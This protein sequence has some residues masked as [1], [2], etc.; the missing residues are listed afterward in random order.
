MKYTKDVPVT[1]NGKELPYEDVKLNKDK[2]K[3]RL[4]R[5]LVCPMNYLQEWLDKIQG[6]NQANSVPTKEFFIK[7]NG[8]AHARQMS[9]IRKLVSEYDNFIRTNRE[10]LFSPA[11]VQ[12]FYRVSDLFYESVS[13][14]KIGNIITINRLIETS[15]CLSENYN[16]PT[17]NSKEG[18]KYV[19]RLLNTIYKTNSTKFLLNFVQ[20]S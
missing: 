9:K 1:K 19:R 5:N 10:K 17:I 14:I 18:S 8:Q 7:M 6:A 13:K 4:N 20:K 3:R 11:F 2:I 12:E 15:L 16:N